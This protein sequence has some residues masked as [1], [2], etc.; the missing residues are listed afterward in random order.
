MLD[1]QK[2][3]QC[4]LL[5]RLLKNFMI[6]ASISRFAAATLQLSAEAVNQ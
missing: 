1:S 5:A 3:L 4:C 2:I 6:L